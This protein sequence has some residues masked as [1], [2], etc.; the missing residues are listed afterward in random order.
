M[1]RKILLAGASALALSATAAQAT[2]GCNVSFTAAGSYTCDV[3]AA[4]LYDFSVLGASGGAGAFGGEYPGG[5]GG[6]GG[7]G[8]GSSYL[9]GLVTNGVTST[10]AVPVGLDDVFNGLPGPDGRIS[11]SLFSADVPGGVP[12]PATWTM[13]LTG[14]GFMGYVLRRRI[15][16]RA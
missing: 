4:G 13:M 14:F 16:R 15:M 6:G 7:L 2:D 3:T 1:I 12:E 11:L 10:T 5:G 9:N 8:G